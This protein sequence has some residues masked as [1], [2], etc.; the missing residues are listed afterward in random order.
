M[1]SVSS[2][3]KNNLNNFF[4]GPLF[5]LLVFFWVPMPCG[6]WVLRRFRGTYCLHLQSDW[7]QFRWML[8]LHQSSFAPFCITG[9][10]TVLTYSN[11]LW[12]GV[13]TFQFSVLQLI[14]DLYSPYLREVLET[15]SFGFQTCV[16]SNKQ[17]G[18]SLHVTASQP[19]VTS[20]SCQIK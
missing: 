1:T 5:Y 16:T 12:M 3:C 6:R 4:T 2:I 19:E 9:S 8:N 7:I 14:L 13:H 17:V 18:C 10:S 20:D 11:L 15:F